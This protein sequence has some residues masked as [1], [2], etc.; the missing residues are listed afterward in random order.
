MY[1][2]RYWLK[3]KSHL[4]SG[5]RPNC[6]HKLVTGS[7]VHQCACRSRVKLLAD[8]IYMNSIDSTT[9]SLK[10]HEDTKALKIMV[11]ELGHLLISTEKLREVKCTRKLGE[12]KMASLYLRTRVS[13]INFRHAWKPQ[14]FLSSYKLTFVFIFPML[15]AVIF[16]RKM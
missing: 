8:R 5:L 13:T 16:Q 10:Q 4:S 15:K 9:M 12:A 3:F 2:W 14:T 6:T 11:L 1:Q 7:S